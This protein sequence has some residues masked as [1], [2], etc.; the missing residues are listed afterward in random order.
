MVMLLK[1]I[2]VHV[3]IF[4]GIISGVFTVIYFSQPKEA[5]TPHTWIIPFAS[6]TVYIEA[7][8]KYF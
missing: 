7:L 2:F 6:F 1:I 8:C 3:K 4:A 5:G